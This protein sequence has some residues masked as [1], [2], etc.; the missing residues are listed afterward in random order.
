MSTLAIILQIMGITI[1]MIILGTVLNKVLGISREK[2]TEFKEKALNLQERMRN[3]QAIG[4]MRMISQ[5]QRETIQL[6]KKIM[7]KQIVPLCLRCVIFIG[8][9]GILGMVYAN[10]SSRLLLYPVLIFGTG[11]VAVYFLFS[12]SFSLIIFGI[13]RLYKKITGQTISSQQKNL[14]EIMEIISPT[15]INSNVSFQVSRRIP[16]RSS[17]TSTENAKITSNTEDES[18]IKSDSWKYRIEK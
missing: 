18:Q 7:V 9:F 1:G 12:I 8:I 13:K 15:Q 3:A 6:T 4:D 10:Y 16:S 17:R 5:L 11:W 14:R 2:I